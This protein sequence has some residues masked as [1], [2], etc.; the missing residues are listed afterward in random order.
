M[1]CPYCGKT[2]KISDVAKV[3]MESYGRPVRAR[4]ECCGKVLF[5]WPVITFSCSEIEQ[6]PRDDWGN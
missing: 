2:A 4:T 3:N 5:V 1:K 6:P